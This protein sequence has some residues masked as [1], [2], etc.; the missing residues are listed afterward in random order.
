[1]NRAKTR[2]CKAKD[3]HNRFE[4]SRPFITFCSADCA[5]SIAH[6]KLAKAK[7]AKAR[8]ER[9]EDAQKKD[10]AKSNKNL[11][12]EAQAAVNRYV[13]LVNY[14]V[15]CIC[16]GK[17]AFEGVR[18]AGHFKARGSSSFL[19][20][21]LWNIHTCCYSCNVAKAGNIHEYRPNLIKKIG[22][23][24]VEFLD[25]APKSR[26]YSDEYLRRLKDIFTRKSKRMKARIG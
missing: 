10:K 15:P 2:K 5:V 23:E 22:L 14:G 11:A 25:T 3:C 1:M 13:N 6:D 12:D 9:K 19:R 4:P 21:N 17:S 18:H 20:F 16:C 7:A 8:K 26:E 24:K